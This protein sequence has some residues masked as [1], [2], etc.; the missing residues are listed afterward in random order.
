MWEGLVAGAWLDSMTSSLRGRLMSYNAEFGVGTLAMSEIDFRWDSDGS[1]A[2]TT[3]VR[4]L[5]THPS[6]VSASY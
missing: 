4:T 3:T 2:A 6:P 5:N 1:I